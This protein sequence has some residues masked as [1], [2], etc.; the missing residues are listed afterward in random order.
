[1]TDSVTERYLQRCLTER[2]GL[3]TVV[4]DT[5]LPPALSESSGHRLLSRPLFVPEKELLGF[6]DDVIRLFDLIT[7][8]P[9]RLFDGDLD[10][11]CAALRIDGRR[12]ALMRALGGGAPPLYGRADMYHDGTAFKLLEFNI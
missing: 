8:L 3:R 1:M 9:E 6:A 7:S 10:R 12:G 5:A 2:T 11:Y 4:R